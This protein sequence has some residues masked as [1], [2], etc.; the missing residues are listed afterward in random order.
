MGE[1]T[2]IAVLV[3]LAV[4][5]PLLMVYPLVHRLGGWRRSGRRLRK[6]AA[7][8]G[9]AFTDPMRALVRHRRG[10]RGLSRR[11]GDG[12]AVG[13][14]GRVL[15]CA[16]EAAEG[17]APGAY[18][19]AVRVGPKTVAVQLA[20][21]WVPE[22]PEPWQVAEADERR[23]WLASDAV[24]ELAEGTGEARAGRV[25][26]PVAVGW[27]AG[28]CVYLD[29]AAGPRLLAVQGEPGAARRLVQALAAQLDGLGG[30]AGVSAVWVADGVH[31]AHRGPELDVLLDRMERGET[32]GGAS[33]LAEEP[34]AAVG[35][36]VIVCAAPSPEQTRRLSGVVA[37]GRAVAI[38]LGAVAAS[39]WALRVDA[40]G[41]VRSEELALDAD[42][43]A[44]G[45]AVA[46]GVKG[47][48]RS[49]APVTTRPVAVTSE[50]AAPAAKGSLF[51]EPEPETT[52]TVTTGASSR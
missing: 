1:I 23:W 38:V 25:P 10:L 18:P 50:P 43:S 42:A 20:A 35:T 14:V 4:M 51:A 48:V 22:A 11:L 21:R 16:A 26:L 19:Y 44:L 29:L 39:C 8:T 28:A 45:R 41:R 36:E 40:G 52:S 47:R 31:P 30:A 15:R 32:A 37:S 49:G 13:V 27:A 24:A 46:R 34:E 33:E 12:R 6:E 3:A 5:L 7:L 17:G 2:R 9:R